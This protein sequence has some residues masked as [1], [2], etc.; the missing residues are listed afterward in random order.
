MG[1]APTGRAGGGSA[2]SAADVAQL[3]GAPGAVSAGSGGVHAYALNPPGSS[4]V[5]TLVP[6]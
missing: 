2:G 1:M 6:V 4:H 5:T 3:S